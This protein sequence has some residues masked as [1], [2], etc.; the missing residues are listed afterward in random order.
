VQQTPPRQTRILVDQDAQ[1]VVGEVVEGLAPVSH[2]LD[3]ST[4]HQLLYGPDGLL[5]AAPARLAHR[6]EVEGAAQNG[7]GG[8][9]LP[10]RLAHRPQAAPK[11]VARAARQRPSRVV[12]RPQRAA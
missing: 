8:Q 2:L 1:L 6:V 11:E 5:L 12:G 7:R 9:Q 3:D 4:R 10:T